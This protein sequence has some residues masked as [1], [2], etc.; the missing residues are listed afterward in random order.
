[1]VPLFLP[2][3][4]H[5]RH[6][7]RGA[8][9]TLTPMPSSWRRVPS[10]LCRPF[11]ESGRI[12]TVSTLPERFRWR[13]CRRAWRS[14]VA[15]SSAW[16]WP[17]AGRKP[18]PA[19]RHAIV[20]RGSRHGVRSAARGPGQVLVQERQIYATTNKQYGDRG[21]LEIT[22]S[23]EKGRITDIGFFGDF[24]PVGWVDCGFESTVFTKEAFG[25]VLDRNPLEKCFSGI[26]KEEIIETAFYIERPFK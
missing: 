5:W 9:G 6:Q 2:H 11:R 26:T 25:A 17:A 18:Y 1:M 12:P 10:T 20:R 3:P 19:P 23:V 22:I 21:C 24:L 8:R 4:R 7:S 16:N 13:S 15:V 14:S